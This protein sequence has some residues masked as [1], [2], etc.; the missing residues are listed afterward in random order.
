MKT[1]SRRFFEDFGAGLIL[2]GLFC[3]ECD[4]GSGRHVVQVGEPSLGGYE[5]LEGFFRQRREQAGSK[6][7]GQGE[8]APVPAG[9]L[10]VAAG[11]FESTPPAF[12]DRDAPV[13][14]ADPTNPKNHVARIAGSD[15]MGFILPVSVPAGT[16]LLV[17]S[18]GL[19]H[20]PETKLV[21]YPDGRMPEGIR[22]QAR[23]M[24]EL[25]TSAIYAAIVSPTG[26]WRCLKFTFH[27]PPRKVKAIWMEGPVFVDDVRAST[28]GGV[29]P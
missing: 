23:P 17:V 8:T 6:T 29:K 19:L 9:E 1:N 14:V 18:L 12:P 15:E 11:S 13:T 27:D 5:P 28:S 4:T 25:G 21:P 16:A 7:S 3:E 2:G 26:Q 22:L 24:N 10:T 20:P